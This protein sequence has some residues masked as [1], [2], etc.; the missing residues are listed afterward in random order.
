[1]GLATVAYHRPMAV[2]HLVEDDQPIR[3]TLARVLASKGHEVRTSATG[4]EAIQSLLEEPPDVVVL[5]L[6]LPDVDGV[7]VLRMLRSVLDVPVI[8]ATARDDE[9]SIVK[10]LNAGADDHVIKPFSGDQ[11]DAR[12]RAVLRRGSSVID[13]ALAMTVGDLEIDTSRRTVTLAG[14][15]IELSRKE[16]DI[17]AVLAAHAGEVVS[18][19]RLYAE[20]WKQPLGGG[21]KTLDVHLSWV[22][23]KLGESARDPRYIR[24]V[25]GVGV[26]LVDPSESP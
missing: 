26:K 11:L 18:R 25:R 14:N 23:R 4:H 15:L 19:D 1:M 20:V 10:V 3:A 5:D 2:V 12:I 9:E 24:T 8:V 7:D 17:L 16:F 6:G 21:D 22:R 13:T